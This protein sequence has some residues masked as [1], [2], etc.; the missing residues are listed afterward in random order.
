MW[1]RGLSLS[2]FGLFCPELTGPLEG[3]QPSAAL[4]ALRELVRIEEGG[5]VCACAGSGV[6]RSKH[7]CGVL[8]GSVHPFDFAVRPG[9]LELGEAMLDAQLSAGEIKGVSP[10]GSLSR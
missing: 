9:V 2:P 4:E 6:S 10:E 3:C 7:D 5:Q 1:W 8:D